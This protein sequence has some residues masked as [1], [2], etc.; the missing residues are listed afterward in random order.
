MSL[1]ILPHLVPTGQLNPILNGTLIQLILQGG[2]SVG[3]NDQL[4]I[5]LDAAQ[6]GPRLRLVMKG[7]IELRFVLA[8]RVTMRIYIMRRG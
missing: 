5:E 8:N 4:R 3:L 2:L 7:A 6:L 1:T